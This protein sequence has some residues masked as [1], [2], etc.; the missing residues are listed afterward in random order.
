M[1]LQRKCLFQ[2]RSDP[3]Q[4]ARNLLFAAISDA[5]SEKQ[6]PHEGRSE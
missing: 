4:S 3:A 5:A 1:V 6:V 2:R